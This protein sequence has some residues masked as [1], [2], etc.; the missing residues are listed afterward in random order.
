[1]TMETSSYLFLIY[2]VMALY[3]YLDKCDIKFIKRTLKHVANELCDCGCGCK[4]DDVKNVMEEVYIATNL[5]YN[6]VT[7]D[8]G[9]RFIL[10]DD[11]ISYQSCINWERVSCKINYDSC[12]KNE[13]V[14]KFRKKMLSRFY[15]VLYNLINNNQ[16]NEIPAYEDSYESLT[17]DVFGN[18]LYDV[19]DN[20][21]DECCKE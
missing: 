4:D 15:M 9:E 6:L 5:L 18:N 17:L 10:L 14:N 12:K 19:I 16:D 3:S 8:E 1:M 2:T 20:C 13:F 7:G 21:I 11:N